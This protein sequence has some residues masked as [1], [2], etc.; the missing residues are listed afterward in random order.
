MENNYI[1]TP[2]DKSSVGVNS[3]NPTEWQ[4][5]KAT[6]T[7][8]SNQAPVTTNMKENYDKAIQEM[9]AA[10]MDVYDPITH[11]ISYR[12]VDDYLKGKSTNEQLNYD[13]ENG[14]RM[15]DSAKK[16]QSAQENVN[17]KNNLPYNAVQGVQN[18]LDK[19][20]TS[21]D[22]QLKKDAK[23]FYSGT[24]S[25]DT[26]NRLAGDEKEYP[27]L[28]DKDVEDSANAKETVKSIVT[29]GGKG[30]P[31]KKNVAA[32]ITQETGAKENAD[33]S[34]NPPIDNPWKQNSQFANGDKSEKLSMIA[35]AFSCIVTALSGGNIPPINFNKI[36]GVDKKYTAYL[37]TID[38]WNNT[39]INPARAAKALQ[40]AENE[41]AL[42]AEQ[43]NKDHPDAFKLLA[44][45]RGA[46][47][48]YLNKSL[49][50]ADALRT[51]AE[52]TRD[53]NV[54]KASEKADSEVLADTLEKLAYLVKR[55]IITREVA[56]KMAYAVAAHQGKSPDYVD[57]MAK[58]SG[59][60][61]L[62]VG[63]KGV[64]INGSQGQLNP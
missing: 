29:N 58:R 35:T 47:G 27:E 43:F 39:V 17:M 12:K 11:D 16:I 4:K 22:E 37:K 52:E 20:A 10:G 63:P 57:N 18:S 3:M 25:Q 38:D 56:L 8:K 60:L 32:V 41:N 15:G 48:D 42:D 44:E 64:G 2:I 23:D 28:T 49:A 53:I 46:L 59:S 13:K 50:E 61:G 6:K 34:F 14:I 24:E 5:K 31:D 1:P 36:M 30:Q 40:T 19:A 33:G 62:S 54:I 7:P 55:N 45:N 26:V 21:D 51:K 9:I